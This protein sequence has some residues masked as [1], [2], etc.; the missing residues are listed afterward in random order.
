[1]RPVAL[2]SGAAAELSIDAPRLVPL[3]SDMCNPPSSM[4][5]I[6]TPSDP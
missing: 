6:S 3:G 5:L 2:A 1:M 4:T